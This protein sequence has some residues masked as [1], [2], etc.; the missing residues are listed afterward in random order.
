MVNKEQWYADR[1]QRYFDKHYSEFDETAEW[2]VNP[3][4]NQWRFRIYEVGL[5]I[6]LTCDDKGRII[7]ERTR[8]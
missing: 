3:G 1:L 8:M 2:Y 5:E 7:E 4:P 6:L